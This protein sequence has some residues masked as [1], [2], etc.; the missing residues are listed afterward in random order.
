MNPLNVLEWPPRVDHVLT[1]GPF[2]LV[3]LALT[4]GN[5][6]LVPLLSS[7]LD[8]KGGNDRKKTDKDQDDH[9]SFG[10]VSSIAATQPVVAFIQS[11]ERYIR[12]VESRKLH[13]HNEH[14][15]DKDNLLMIFYRTQAAKLLGLGLSSS[16]CAVEESE[17]KEEG[18]TE[19]P[20][21]ILRAL[22]L[23]ITSSDA[24]S[25]IKRLAEMDPEKPPN[26]RLGVVA[27]PFP[28]SPD[29]LRPP[30]CGRPQT[31]RRPIEHHH[32][33]L[34]NRARTTGRRYF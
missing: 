7:D 9:M 32:Q 6:S 28:T 2:C 8:A 31:C 24:V 14:D 17:G 18:E 33:I 1:V 30:T 25:L 26:F 4:C 34:Q 23:P 21:V 13:D 22:P 29:L 10:I 11:M 19:T 3:F 15:K 20:G 12:K 5:S 27:A 16:K